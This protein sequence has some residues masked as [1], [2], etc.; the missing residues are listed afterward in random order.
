MSQDRPNNHP[1]PKVGVY[2][3]HCGGNISDQVDVEQVARQ[4]AG[5]PGVTAAHHY[6]FMCSDPGQQIILEDLTS[7]RVDRVVVASCAPALHETT[8]RE[9]LRRAG[10]NPYLYEHANIREQVS[11]VHHGP[12]AT[13][14]ATALA[15]AAMEGEPGGR[16]LSAGTSAANAAAMAFYQSLGLRA[17]ELTYHHHLH[18]AF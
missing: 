4:A 3:C 17:V 16:P 18:G 7:G 12:G 5:L 9:V 13:A 1:E 11:W 8:F 14:N 2:V 15:A 10:L 6:S